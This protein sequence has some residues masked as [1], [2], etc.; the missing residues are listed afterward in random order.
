MNERSLGERTLICDSPGN[1]ARSVQYDGSIPAR[2][3]LRVWNR[4]LTDRG[5]T[6]AARK[7][8]NIDLCHKCILV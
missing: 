8:E 2:G 3:I 7:V 4:G 6:A 5:F 1:V